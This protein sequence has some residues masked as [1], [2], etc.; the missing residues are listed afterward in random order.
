MFAG[1]S[2]NDGAFSSE[3]DARYKTMKMLSR[4]ADFIDA[5]TAAGALPM[6]ATG[7]PCSPWRVATAEID[8][9]RLAHNARL[10]QLEGRGIGVLDWSGILNDGATP[11]R[12]PVDLRFDETHPNA[13]GCQLQADQLLAA[14]K[15]AFGIA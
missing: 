12:L 13:A 8:A 6:V 7:L 5:A 1:W 3:G 9:V 10:L 11:Q 4:V 2:P 14:V 15:S